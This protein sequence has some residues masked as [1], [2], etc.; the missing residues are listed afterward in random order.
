ML[1]KVQWTCQLSLCTYFR[2]NAV[3]GDIPLI[4]LVLKSMVSLST[5]YIYIRPRLLGYTLSGCPN[6]LCS[7]PPLLGFYWNR[8]RETALPQASVPTIY[9]Q[10]LYNMTPYTLKYGPGLGQTL[11]P[12]L[13][14]NR[15]LRMRQPDH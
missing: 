14:D 13:G 7:S 5:W 1:R 15:T 10:H 3:T 2:D 8:W 4:S 6:R 11:F 9:K 12:V